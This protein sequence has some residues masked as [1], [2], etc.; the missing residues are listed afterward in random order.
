MN[1]TYTDKAKQE[2]EGFE[3]LQDATTRLEGVLGKSIDRVKAEWDRAEDEKG[4]SR[5][6]LRIS[7]NSGVAAASF[8]PHE[9][10]PSF[11]LQYRL[12]RLWDELLK[13]RIEKHLNALQAM[14]GSEI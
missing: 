1:V 7:D 9:L 12:H 5:Y 13:L 4:H 11:H 3:R 14:D 2:H 10:I 8:D 6:Q